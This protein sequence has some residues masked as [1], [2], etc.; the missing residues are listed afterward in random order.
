VI[1]LPEK[2]YI[3]PANKEEFL[4]IFCALAHIYTPTKPIPICNRISND[5]ILNTE[6]KCENTM[7]RS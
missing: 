4:D 1:K 5:P 6:K 7:Y 3:N 2:A